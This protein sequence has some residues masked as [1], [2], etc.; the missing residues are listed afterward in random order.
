MN[1][2]K[3]LIDVEKD[4]MEALHRLQAG[5]PS[6]LEPPRNGAPIPINFTTVAKEAGR[7]R[8]LIGTHDCAYPKVR[9]AVNAARNG[10]ASATVDESDHEPTPSEIIDELTKENRRLT[11]TINE[12]ATRLAVSDDLVAQLSSALARAQS[13]SARP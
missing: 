13:K 11:A 2:S 9:A 5:K 7:S 1:G 8:T 10:E 6:V 3:S 12:L 4:F